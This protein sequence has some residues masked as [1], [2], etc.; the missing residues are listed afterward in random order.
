MP[1]FEFTIPFSPY[2]PTHSSFKNLTGQRFERWLVICLYGRNSTGHP[3]WLCLCD[4]GE[5]NVKRGT[6]LTSG[7]SRSCGCLAAELSSQRET[8]HGESAHAGNSPEY[9]SYTQAKA[10]CNNPK[11]HAYKRYGGRGIEFRFT[12]YEEFLSAAGRRPTPK[13]S[14]DRIDNDGHYEAGN[15]KWSTSREQGRN[16][17]TTRLVT[18]GGEAKSVSEWCQ[19]YHMN[20]RFVYDRIKKGWDV[21][22]AITTPPLSRQRSS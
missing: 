19:I 1:D 7:K 16:M 22:Q 8:R 4:C 17:S 15:V 18:I 10:R 2:T 5:W 11:H 3:F 14:I 21:V 6:A 12:S 13:H 20:R 9:E